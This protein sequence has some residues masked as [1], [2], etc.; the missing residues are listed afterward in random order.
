M[1]N[2][3]FLTGGAILVALVAVIGISFTS[4]A[5]NGESGQNHAQFKKNCMQNEEC[6]FADKL[7]PEER[8]A[9]KKEWEQKKEEIMHALENGDY[10]AWLEAVGAD[11]LAAQEV[12]EEEFPRL[13]EAHQLM[14]E[15]KEKI[16][17]A[18][19]IKEEIGLPMGPKNKGQF[20]KHFNPKLFGA[21]QGAE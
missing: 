5:A 1:T 6:P 13:L 4:F 8:E 7:S 12:T 14:N 9:K 3:K 15:A 20:G 11:S 17:Q 19:Q 21:S 10:Q 18:K 16:E 2:K